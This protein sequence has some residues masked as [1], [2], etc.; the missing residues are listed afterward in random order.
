MKNPHYTHEFLCKS[1]GQNTI[2]YTKDKLPPKYCSPLCC[3][4]DR[5]G[6]KI[7]KEKSL[8][9]VIYSFEKRVIKKEGCWGW[10][11]YINKKGYSIL[12]NRYLKED[13]AHRIS[14]I[15]HKGEIPSGYFILHSCHNKYCT[16]PDHLRVGTHKENMKDKVKAFRQAFKISEKKIKAI[17]TLIKSKKFSDEDIADMLNA[18]KNAVFAVKEKK[19]HI[20]KRV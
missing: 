13:K 3:Q 16:N 19:L 8:K 15:I 14:Y 2:K 7:N 11:G 9:K 4:K 17:E 12:S 20:A 18:S 6:Y 1:C 10:K 5:I